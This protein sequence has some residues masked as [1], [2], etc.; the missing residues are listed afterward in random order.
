[1]DAVNMISEGY[2]SDSS[3]DDF[4]DAAD[5]SRDSSDSEDVGESFVDYSSSSSEDHSSNS[6]EDHVSDSDF[7]G[8][9]IE[10][11]LC[12]P[13]LIFQTEIPCQACTELI[14]LN[15]LSHLQL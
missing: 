10:E 2:F 14:R 15:L 9:Y 8:G 1:M 5:Y 6:S 11:P 12:V 4:V 7:Y 13:S 3:D